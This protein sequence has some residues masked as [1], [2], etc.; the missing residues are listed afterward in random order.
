MFISL[1]LV[2][3][4]F[5]RIFSSELAIDLLNKD[6]EL[7]KKWKASRSWFYNE[8]EKVKDCF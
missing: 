7:K 8:M 3:N 5:F 1:V 4:V 6:E 2:L